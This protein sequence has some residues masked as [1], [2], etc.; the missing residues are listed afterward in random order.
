MGVIGNVLT[1]SDVLLLVLTFALLY[2]GHWTPWT[3]IPGATDARGK[4]KPVL[5][6]VYGLGIVLAALAAWS[7]LR[8]DAGII[9]V[10]VW[11]PVRFL[12]LDCVAAGI[13]T[14]LPRLFRMIREYN[15]RGEDLDDGQAKM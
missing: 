4:L 9:T 11:E 2:G 5:C 14:I 15:A 7:Y 12:A 10:G 3:I 1:R 6:Y 8:W 13:G